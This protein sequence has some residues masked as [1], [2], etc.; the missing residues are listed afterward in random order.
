M[1]NKQTW[2]LIDD[3]RDGKGCD[4]VARTSQMGLELLRRHT[5]DVLAMDHDLGANSEMEGAKVLDI[6]LEEGICPKR[7]TLVTSNPSGRDRMILAL[8]SNGYVPEY[9]GSTNFY[10]KL[11]KKPAEPAK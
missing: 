6:A 9:N 2:L 5:W 8:R 4:A 7:V 10:I 11:S 1:S 3:E